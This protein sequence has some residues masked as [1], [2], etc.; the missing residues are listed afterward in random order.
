MKII[1]LRQRITITEYSR[2]FTNDYGD[3][4][5]F[6][7]DESGRLLEM[8]DCAYSNYLACLAGKVKD[9]TDKGVVAQDRKWTEPAIGICPF[10][11]KEVVLE[12]TY[13]G[14]CQCECGQW[15]NMYGQ[16]LVPPQYWE[17]DNDDDP[18]NN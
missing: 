4:Y 6:P 8:S 5:C 11:G 12:S 18:Y 7:C 1:S 13:M 15:F 10:C 9:V 14:A 2:D 17:S 16:N 3:G